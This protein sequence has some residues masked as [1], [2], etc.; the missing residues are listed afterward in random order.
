VGINDGSLC[1][2]GRFGYDY[3]HHADRLTHPLIRERDEFREATWD[4][5]LSLVAKKL[6]RLKEDSGGECL[7]AILPSRGT[8]EEVYLLQKWIRLALG[9]NNV[10]SGGRLGSAATLAGLSESL[11]YGAT[12]NGFDS[13]PGADVIL[14][15]GADPDEDNLIFAHRIRQAIQKNDARLIL[16]DPR[17]TSLEEF[18]NVWLRPFPGTDVAWINGVIRVLIDE[19]LMDDRS[20]QERGEGFKELKKSVSS[21]VPESVEKLTGIPAEELQ[22]AARLLGEAKR[23]AIAYGTGITQHVRGTDG[24]KALANLALMTRTVG[25]EEGGL[26]A[27]HSQS[28]CQGAFDMGGLP[29]YLP[30]YQRIDDPEV[31]DRFENAWHGELPKK[32]GL[33]F[34]KMFDAIQAGKI[35]GLIVAGE[36]PVMTLPNPKRLKAGFNKLKFL[37]VIDTFLTETAKEADVVLPG[38]TFAEKDGTFTSMERRVQRVRQAIPPMGGKAEWEIISLVASQ[39]DHPMEYHHPSEIFEEMA[40]LTPLYRGMTY[41]T[42]DKGGIQWPCPESGHPGT[43]ILYREGFVNGGGRVCPITYQKPEEKPR[44]EFPFWLTVGGILYNYQ[45]GT[46]ERRASGLAQWYPET[47]LEIHPEDAASL[48]I[49][50]GDRVRLSSPRG[51][52][53]IKA[54][55]SECAARG[56]V[57]LA[58]SFYDVA[59]GAI[60]YPEFDAV[61]G[62][63]QYK[64]CAAKVERI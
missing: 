30:G 5:A 38:A 27:L 24:V 52:I 21:Y 7:G 26:Y 12:T 49:S 9:S 25:N 20:I 47:A 29:E 14:V 61:S 41:Q 17:R 46:K 63:P 18:A 59:V 36:N 31:R 13:L 39:M 56:M 48:G 33:S 40:S 32:P 58:P 44:R 54:R 23:A 16:V 1:V 51:Q 60:L 62:T 2:K 4:D 43:P 15:V 10:D 35:K 45:I 19:K 8:N 3:I 55:I 6:R 37:V 53:E 57:Y 22:R 34:C 64:A 11:G 28:N 50:D 42:L